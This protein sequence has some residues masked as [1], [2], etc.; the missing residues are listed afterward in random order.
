MPRFRIPLTLF[1]KMKSAFLAFGLFAVCA[2]LLVSSCSFAVWVRVFNTTD[3]AIELQLGANQ[4]TIVV[5]AGG[6][7]RV[8]WA[9]ISRG[10]DYG[11]VVKDSGIEQFYAVVSRSDDGNYTQAASLVLPKEARKP[12][13][14]APE[15][16]VEY[17]SDGT[18][19]L[20]DASQEN[21]L[22][23]LDPQPAGF[24]KKPTQSSKVQRP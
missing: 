17:S 13:Q 14:M 4:H 10:R 5:P 22:C 20:L 7:D 16:F 15:Y 11:F 24:P 1:G 6:S 21:R 2:A 12:K 19:S 8:L 9:S 18:L 23:R 3:H